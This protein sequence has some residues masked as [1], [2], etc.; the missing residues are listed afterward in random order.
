MIRKVQRLRK[1]RRVG[2]VVKAKAV[3]ST[4]A[5]RELT[6]QE[7]LAKRGIVATDLEAIVYLW[8]EKQGY[9]DPQD[10]SFQ[11]GVFGGRQE[12]GGQVADFILYTARAY[13]LVIRVMG[14]H[15][16]T[17][18]DQQA[19]DEGAK[20]ALEANGFDVVDVW[21]RYLLESP[22]YTMEQALKGV[23]LGQ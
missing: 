22:D 10:F 12:A 8:L 18:P 7:I 1:A 3:P 15:W 4:L 23:E 9:R 17:G 5:T 20:S 13:P 14:E 2:T 6:A 11:S 16:H 19:K 21:E